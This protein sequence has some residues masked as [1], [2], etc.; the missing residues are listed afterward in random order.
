MPFAVSSALAGHMITLRLPNSNAMSSSAHVTRVR[1]ICA[2][3]TRKS[4][5]VC[6]RICSDQ[7]TT[8]RCIRESRQLGRITR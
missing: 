4:S 7:M 6:P 2:I 3:E 8:A 5:T 1:R